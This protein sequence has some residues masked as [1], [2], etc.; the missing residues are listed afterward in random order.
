MSNKVVIEI[1]D[2]AAIINCNNQAAKTIKL[3]SLVKAFKETDSK[4]Q[5]PILPIGT[6]KYSEYG[7]Y[8]NIIIYIAPSKFNAT[9]GNN[10]FENCCRPAMLF[11]VQL[12]TSNSGDYIISGTSIFGIKDSYLM[13]SENT[14]LFGLPF[15]NIGSGGHICWGSN[16]MAGTLKSLMGIPA[17]ID[18][19]FNSPFNNHLFNTDFLKTFGINTPEKLFEYIKDKDVFPLE[20]L[21]GLGRN[22]TLSSL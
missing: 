18:R 13:L 12:S 20:L 11:K 2:N 16:S 6:I 15:P 22:Y 10:V 3:E 19:L 1:L 17:Y 4:I 21:E 8:K 9:V 14:Q 5:S 7:L